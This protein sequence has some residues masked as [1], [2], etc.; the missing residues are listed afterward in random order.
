MKSTIKM[1][2]VADSVDEVYIS[3]IL[4]APGSVVQAGEPLML[5]E[6]DKAS[7]ELP[8]PVAGTVI[9]ILVAVDQAVSTGAPIVE[10]ESN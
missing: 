8:S 9:A 5:V 10:I 6:T 4:V 7:V 2:K 1:P 3:E